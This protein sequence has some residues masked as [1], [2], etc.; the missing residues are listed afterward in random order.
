MLKIT[1]DVDGTESTNLHGA[2]PTVSIHPSTEEAMPAVVPCSARQPVRR[3]AMSKGSSGEAVLGGV[4][5]AGVG[6]GVGVGAD[7]VVSYD[8]PLA[9]DLTHVRYL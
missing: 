7:L 5:S 2:T 4:Q 9:Q 8:I 1:D 3:T 6:G